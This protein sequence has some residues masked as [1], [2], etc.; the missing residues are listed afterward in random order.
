MKFLF[1]LMAMAASASALAEGAPAEGPM[2]AIGQFVFL[3]GFLLIF[4]FLLWRPQAKRQKEHK[5]LISNLSKGDEVVM[6]GGMLG[7]V[8]K[9]SE[10][11]VVM[12]VANGIELPV[13]KVAVTMVLPKG[14]IKE[15][16]G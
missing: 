16:L 6:A 2:G 7:K 15:V 4:Y 3:G 1:A 12:E 13:Q 11:F 9:V 14:T 10:D 5:N 8:T